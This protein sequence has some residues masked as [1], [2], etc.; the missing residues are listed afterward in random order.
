MMVR[1]GCGRV[2]GGDKVCSESVD[3]ENNGLRVCRQYGRW[4]CRRICGRDEWYRRSSEKEALDK[5]EKSNDMKGNY[6]EDDESREIW[7]R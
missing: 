6:I 2:V 3:D 5:G 4:I 1:G 7:S